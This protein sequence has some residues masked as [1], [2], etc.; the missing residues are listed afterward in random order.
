MTRVKLSIA[1][2][3]PFAPLSPRLVTVWVAVKP[4]VAAFAGPDM[5]A[6]SGVATAAAAI[7]AL[8]IV[9]RTL[10]PF[11]LLNFIV[12]LVCVRFSLPFGLPFLRGGRPSRRPGSRRF[13]LAGLGHVGRDDD[14]VGDGADAV[15]RL[16]RPV[17]LERADMR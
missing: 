5:V 17:Q 2:L 11:V 6:I 13:R 12:L 9:L 14:A 10:V 4:L 15:I 8:M 3:P 1:Q 16:D 7:A